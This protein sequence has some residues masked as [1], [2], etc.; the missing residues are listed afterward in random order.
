ME[1]NLWRF[2]LTRLNKI[3]PKF[4][5]ITGFCFFSLSV[6][7]GE[8]CDRFYRKPNIITRVNYGNVLYK[9]VPKSEILKFDKLH[10]PDKTMGVTV[11]NIEIKYDFDFDRYKVGDGVCVNLSSIDFFVG[12]PSLDVLID[13][14]Y[15][16]DSC[17]YNAIKNHEKQHVN[18]YQKELKYYGNLLAKELRNIIDNLGVMYFPKYVTEKVVAKKID[19][20]IS[21]NT[22]ILLLRE[23]METEIL[24]QNSQ[25][26]TDTEYL[27]VNSICDNW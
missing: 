17:E 1:I 26:D 24:E 21:E 16:V 22:N 8:S 14:K 4:I 25:L 13:S 5:K 19:K 27:R 10:N 3:I 23:K 7:A 6:W 9:S 11:A 18:V 12:Y 20:I 2:I 15:P